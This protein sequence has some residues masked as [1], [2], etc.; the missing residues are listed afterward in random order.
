MARPRL[1]DAKRRAAQLNLRLRPAELAAVRAAARLLELRPADWAHRAVL[2][3]LGRPAAEPSTDRAVLDEAVAMRRELIR[4]GNLLN[5]AV[6]KLHADI[7]GL[8]QG[9]EDLP[10][11]VVAVRDLVTN[12]VVSRDENDR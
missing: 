3:S 10:A 11:L 12:R 9:P 7:G 6:R 4:I 2:A 8:G 1:E 5:Q